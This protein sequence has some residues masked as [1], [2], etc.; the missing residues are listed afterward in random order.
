MKPEFDPLCPNINTFTG[1]SIDPFNVDPALICIEDIAHHL[2]NMCRF[3]GACKTFYS[4]AQHCYN[5]SLLCRRD[6]ALEGL[7]HDGNEYLTGDIATPTKRRPEMKP[8]RDAEDSLDAKIRYKYHLPSEISHDVHV[9]D[10]KMGATEARD[11]FSDFRPTDGVYL[12]YV[13]FED[14][15]VVPWES[16]A[17]ERMFLERYYQLMEDWLPPR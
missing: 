3:T 16:I 1:L 11:L 15:I 13:A 4:V 14:F 12:K 5:V 10:K 9:T 17:A 8:I 6:H 2:A 7:L